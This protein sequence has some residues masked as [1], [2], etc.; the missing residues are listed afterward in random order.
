MPDLA[1][2]R[3]RVDTDALRR[4]IAR[5]KLGIAAL[6]IL[7]LTESVSYS[8]SEMSGLSSA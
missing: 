4:G 1:E 8:A 3:L 6:E 7:Q 2:R 5:G